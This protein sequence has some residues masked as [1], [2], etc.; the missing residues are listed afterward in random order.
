LLEEKYETFISNMTQQ[1][2]ALRPNRKLVIS[3][4][5]VD[6]VLCTENCDYS[7]CFSLDGENANA[8]I[9]FAL[10][11]FVGIAYIV[12]H[13]ETNYARAFKYGRAWIYWNEDS[14]GFVIG[15]PYQFVQ[16]MVEAAAKE[17][18]SRLGWT[19]TK[20]AIN[21]GD[22]CADSPIYIDRDFCTAAT[23]DE[24]PVKFHAKDAMC[25]VCGCD[26]VHPDEQAC[27]DC[28]SYPYTRCYECDCALCQE[29][30]RT[31]PDDLF[32]CADCFYE[33]FTECSR[34]D[35]PVEETHIVF[36]R[37]FSQIYQVEVCENCVEEYQ[38]CAG[39]SEL[40]DKLNT[41]K[42]CDDCEGARE[43]VC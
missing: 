27:E 16:S 41:D 24:F 36:T 8:P 25:F 11:P 17:L 38:E 1:A 6:Y 43:S 7:S 23:V 3:F 37:S 14:T 35:V 12:R 34:C 18:I 26:T 30:A 31:G 33:K 5:P 15:R 21:Y 2:A 10:S 22:F 13:S 19:A 28:C 29:D 39:C 32:Y 40:F 42:K 9:S 4:N 20:T